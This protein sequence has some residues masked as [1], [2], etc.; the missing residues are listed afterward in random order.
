[1]N[2]ETR[3]IQFLLLLGYEEESLLPTCWMVE[4]AVLVTG[5]ILKLWWNISIFVRGMQSQQYR[6]IKIERII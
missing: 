5:F 2:S 1:M 4:T 3:P 6:E